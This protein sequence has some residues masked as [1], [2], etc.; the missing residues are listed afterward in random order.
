MSSAIAIAAHPDDIEFMMAG[1]LLLLKRAGYE[2][3]YFNLSS[4]NCG[5]DRHG[6]AM[7]SR[8]RRREARRA[9]AILGARWYPPIGDDLELL[10][11][12]TNLRR[13]AAVIRQ[14]PAAL[15]P[16]CFSHGVKD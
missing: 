3:H 5:S 11:T 15:V 1:T 2:V 4:G 8:I 13:V 9:A 14:A 7:T 10:Y 16:S 6:S 12:V